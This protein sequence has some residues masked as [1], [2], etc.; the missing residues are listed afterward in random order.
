MRFRSK[1][2]SINISF[3]Y[4]KN[5]KYIINGII[6]SEKHSVRNFK[7]ALLR[8]MNRHNLR[9][10]AEQFGCSHIAVEKHLNEIDKTWKY[11]V[12]I[13]H[14]L[15]PHQLQH[16]VDTCMDLMT[17]HRNYEWLR[18][19]IIGDEKWVLYINYTHTGVSK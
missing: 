7:I 8:A 11:G 9:C 16:R 18:N 10:L 6:E 2:R 1:L 3:N 15:S 4:G 13:P 14:E 5:L 12:W 17:S 19:L